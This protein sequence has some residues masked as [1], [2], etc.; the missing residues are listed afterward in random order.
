MWGLKFEWFPDGG[1][2]AQ[3]HSSLVGFLWGH[4][5]VVDNVSVL[6]GDGC[7]DAAFAFGMGVG[8][9][10]AGPGDVTVAGRV[11]NVAPFAKNPLCSIVRFAEGEVIGG[12]VLLA[13]GESFFG[14]GELVHESET[15]VA[16][17]GGEIDGQEAAGVALRGL[18]TDLL[19]QSG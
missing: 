11:M 13:S 4:V 15:K 8:S 2:V 17:F 19:A 9:K 6:V 16:F 10:S 3:E 1:I 12:D 5:R 7:A 18:P 14:D